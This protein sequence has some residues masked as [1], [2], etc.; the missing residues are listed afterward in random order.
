MQEVKH[1]LRELLRNWLDE[2]EKPVIEKWHI[3]HPARELC[4]IEHQCEGDVIK[5][6]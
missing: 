5:G 3:T 1:Y 6:M 2:A 4:N